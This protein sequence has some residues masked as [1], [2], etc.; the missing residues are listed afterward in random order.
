MPHPKNPAIVPG[1]FFGTFCRLLRLGLV[2]CGGMGFLVVMS[3]L[4]PAVSPDVHKDRP[5]RFD[6]KFP[7]DLKLFRSPDYFGE[8]EL[9]R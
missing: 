1:F 9:D 6:R 8:V 3:S 2:F 4:G 5:M 7:G